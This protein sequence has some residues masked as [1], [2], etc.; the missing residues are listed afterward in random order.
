MN[1]KWKKHLNIK[2]GQTLFGIIR[3]ST[4]TYGG[5]YP[6]TLDYIDWNQELLIFTIDQPCGMVYCTFRDAK[7]YLFETEREAEE[8][9]TMLEFGVGVSA[10]HEWAY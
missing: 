4:H 3:S 7:H 10:Y 8:K 5:V 9:M 6:V 2:I 1:L